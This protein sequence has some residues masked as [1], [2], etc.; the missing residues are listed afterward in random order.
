M[1]VINVKDTVQIRDYIPRGIVVMEDI[2]GKI[3]FRKENMILE[4]GRKAILKSVFTENNIEFTGL[5]IGM[6]G[7]SSTS[8]MESLKEPF[9]DSEGNNKVIELVIPKT[10]DELEEDE[11]IVDK[12]LINDKDLTILLKTEPIQLKNFEGGLLREIGLLIKDKDDDENDIDVLFSRLSVD[13]TPLSA[14]MEYT[15]KYY[16][17]F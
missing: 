15:I 2:D 12:G 14:Q 11:Y 6:D 13:P 7:S 1:E 3:I 17:Y 4:A 10:T 9:K 8:D 5:V 16:I